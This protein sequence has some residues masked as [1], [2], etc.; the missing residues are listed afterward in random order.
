MN[1]DELDG[2]KGLDKRRKNWVCVALSLCKKIVL[3]LQA[4]K[5]RKS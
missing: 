4:V 2:V 1:I 3:K 5:L